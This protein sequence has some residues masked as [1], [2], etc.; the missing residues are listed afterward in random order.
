MMS[1]LQDIHL[2]L[3]FVRIKHIL[4]PSFWTKK[5]KFFSLLYFIFLMMTHLSQ[6]IYSSSLG[7]VSSC[8]EARENIISKDA[9]V[10]NE[11][12]WEDNFRTQTL[13][14]ISTR[15]AHWQSLWASRNSP[16]MQFWPHASCCE[17]FL[18]LL[19]VTSSLHNYKCNKQQMLCRLLFLHLG[20]WFCARKIT[21]YKINTWIIT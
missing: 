8:V 1:S 5:N 7:L 12:Q 2:S 15:A 20:Y 19:I 18:L 21:I 13:R 9:N 4:L 3:Y 14:K 16:I 11:F 10:W 6:N 17:L